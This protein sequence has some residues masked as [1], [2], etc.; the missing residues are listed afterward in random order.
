MFQY[1]GT[2]NT[3]Q[4]EG[5]AGSQEGSINGSGKSTAALK[6]YGAS[7][8]VDIPFTAFMDQ[9]LTVGAE[10]GRETLHDPFAMSQRLT[11]G[12]IP[13]LSSGPRD[14]NSD[15]T[16]Y[17]L[18]LEDNIEVTREFILT[19]GVRFDHNSLFGNN[20]S[21]SLN[22]SYEIMDGLQVK[23]GI[24]RAFKA[25]NL[26]QSNPNYLYFTMGN[27]CPIAYPSL[28]GGCYV[29][30]NADLKP[31]TSINKEIGI[32]YAKDG[33]NAGIT[34]FHNDY[35]NKIVAG[36]VPIGTA[37]GT[38]GRIFQWYNTPEAVVEGLEGNLT[39]PL[40]PTLTWSNNFT[41]ML[42]S[43]D[44]T[45]G[46]PLS[47]IP[48]YTINSWLD[49]QATEDLGFQLS[50]THYGKQE[51]RTLTSRGAAAAGDEL[52]ERAPYTLIGVS[53]N[54]VLSENLRISGGVSNLLNK[55]LFREDNS[56][57]AG[58]NTYNEPGRAYYVSL[59][60]SF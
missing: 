50:V 1:E 21:P 3:R 58:A 27:G 19:P 32:N 14:P 4:N 39:V 36:T 33:W 44:K 16:T 24:A 18:Y 59:T 43:K 17:A 28:G 52:R 2:D 29:Q 23:G 22:A 38:R 34:Y 5:L 40:H 37:L 7:G 30:G 56:G 45:T 47:I 20:F 48:E 51:P 57:G 6:D 13:G 11:G 55:Q 15:A 35:K 25:P 26:Y 46:Q 10:A 60:A 53:A 54:Y 42:E 49:W 8:K 41:Y 9:V 31:E 12:T